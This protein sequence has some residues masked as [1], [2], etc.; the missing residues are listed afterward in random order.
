[1]GSLVIAMGA[2][3]PLLIAN[4][5]ILCADFSFRQLESGNLKFL[6]GGKNGSP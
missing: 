6:W 1:M 2:N 5:V 4:P 3:F